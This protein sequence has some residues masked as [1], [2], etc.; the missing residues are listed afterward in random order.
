MQI[1]VVPIVFLV[2]AFVAGFAVAFHV[3]AQPLMR[4]IAGIAFGFGFVAVLAGIAFAG[5]LA[6]V[7]THR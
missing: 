2:L 4:V 5:C 7:A 6:L 3:T 1:L